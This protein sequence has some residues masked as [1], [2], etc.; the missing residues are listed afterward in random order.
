LIN[1]ASIHEVSGQLEHATEAVNTAQGLYPQ[2]P[3]LPIIDGN[4]HRKRGEPDLARRS[5]LRALALDSR[6]VTAH[7]NLGLL[8]HEQQQ[9]ERSTAH[10]RA[11]LELDPRHIDS[12]NNLGAVFL[13]LGEFSEAIHYL[14]TAVELDGAELG[15]RYNLAIAYLRSGQP[16]PAEGQLRAIQ[17]I[18]PNYRWT[19]QLLNQA[20][21]AQARD[22]KGGTVSSP[23]RPR[24]HR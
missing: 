11:A 6:N 1:L 2:N 13:Q 16:G 24:S 23:R 12:L 4:I 15:S 17:A 19:V 5:Y 8:A 18:D 20:L 21:H 10:Y 9:R 14:Q 22:K 3:R 7:Y